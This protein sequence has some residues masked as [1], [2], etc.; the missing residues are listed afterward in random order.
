VRSAFFWDL[1]WYR[2]VIL[3]QLFETI[4][5]SHHKEK[6]NT[7]RVVVQN[8]E[9]KIPLGRHKH[10]WEENIE[11]DLKAGLKGME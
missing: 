6:R 7:H 5:Q 8:P 9:R 10:S 4:Y 3:Y 1:T 11:M 2:L